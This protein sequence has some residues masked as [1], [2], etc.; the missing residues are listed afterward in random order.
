MCVIVR[1][2][3]APQVILNQTP[4]RPDNYIR[5]RPLSSARTL[6]TNA[7]LSSYITVTYVFWDG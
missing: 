3:C 2:I 6:L 1:V 7:K 4:P 5:L